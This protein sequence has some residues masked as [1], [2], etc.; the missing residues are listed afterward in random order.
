MIYMVAAYLIIWAASFGLI[1]SMVRRQ[2]NLR[3]E[4]S[5]LKEISQ[6]KEPGR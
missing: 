5:A 1:F 3:R 4:I 2:S 6:E